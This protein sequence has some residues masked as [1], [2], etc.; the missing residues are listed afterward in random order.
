MQHPDLSKVT[1]DTLPLSVF[2]EKQVQADMLRLDKIHPV[3]S[4]NKWFKLKYHLENFYSGNYKGI[5]T[6]GG[7]WSN[8]IAATAAVCFLNKIS[9]AGIIRGERP[10]QLSQTLRNAIEYGMQPEFIP[11]S[12]YKDKTGEDSIKNILE[13][14]PGYYLIPEG[15]A[16][17]EGEKG[18]GEMLNL[19]NKD[20]YTHIACAIGTATM[21]NGMM[22]ASTVN[23]QL[24]GIPVLKGL[25]I[26]AAQS[27]CKIFYDYHFGGYAGHTPELFGFMND[28]YRET[29]IPTDFVYTGK[30]AFAVIDL[31]RKGF[32]W[33]GSRVLI[34]HSGG[35]QG[36]TSLT[37]GTL[38]F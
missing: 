28:F 4:G 19:V 38:I 16:G 22:A 18:A 25:K 11:R 2:K 8:H 35:L 30:L 20:E 7:A 29:G 14:Y 13:K 23:Q 26:I 6:F 10:A 3:I 32:F 12:M 1:I 37:Q 17:T 34:I 36:N 9:C 27:S 21:F 15:G 31:C 33:P 24:T 5:F